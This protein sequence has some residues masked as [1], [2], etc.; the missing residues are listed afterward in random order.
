MKMPIKSGNVNKHSKF[1]QPPPWIY[2]ITL[3]L[4]QVKKLK[5]LINIK[6]NLNQNVQFK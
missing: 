3:K 4:P 2:K 1:Q 6:T 5:A